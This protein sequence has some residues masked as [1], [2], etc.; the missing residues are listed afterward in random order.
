MIVAIIGAGNG[1]QTMAAD[2]TRRG[3]TVNLYEDPSRFY[4][5]G[6]LTTHKTIT[7]HVEEMAKE[8]GGSYK[9]N[10]VTDNLEEALDGATY[11]CVVMPD[12]Y[13][14]YTAKKLKGVI[15]KDQTLVLYPSALGSLIFKQILGDECP[16]VAEANNLPYNTRTMGN[17][18][19]HTKSTNPTKISF[20][21]SNVTEEEYERI[22]VL[23][24]F[25]GTYEDVLENG[26]SLLNPV[27][28]VGPSM[29][30]VG[31][32]E[33]PSRG[34]FYMYANFTPAG[35]KINY[36]LDKERKAVAR[37]YGYNLRPFDDYAHLPA[38]Q[39]H[40]WQSV[41]AFI[42]GDLDLV[43]N[44][45]SKG[46]LSINYRYFNEDI[47]YS[48]MSWSQLGDVA[49]VDTPM[50]DAMIELLCCIQQHDWRE[51]GLT[52]KRLGLEGMNV[53]EIKA[54]VRNG[55]IA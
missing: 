23:H 41:Y 4:D 31:Q 34:D 9:L 33:Q 47:G 42:R 46:P 32:I 25:V 43:I 52:L 29:M 15:K 19:V 16:I 50:M 51:D 38:D 35:A 26:L 36:T 14:A 44:D 28:H 40:T 30:N 13:Y 1:A 49:G 6:T 27:I 20:F 55:G 12:L 21:P 39:E 17:G 2:F 54:F 5:L 10:M 18:H 22:K 24:P 11:V 48:I 53:E 3:L 45:G 8:L 7:M 37:A